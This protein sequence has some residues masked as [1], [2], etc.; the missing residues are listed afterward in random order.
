[1]VAVFSRDD[2]EPEHL[3]D[4]VA[5]FGLEHAKDRFPRLSYL[6][7]DG[8]YKGKSKEWIEKALAGRLR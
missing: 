7:L 6:W 2:P 1:M 4:L 3:V 5:L 8:G